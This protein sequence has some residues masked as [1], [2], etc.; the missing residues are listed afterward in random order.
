MT[1]INTIS[2]NSHNHSNS[3]LVFE[4]QLALIPKDSIV[5]NRKISSEEKIELL[6]KTNKSNLNKNNSTNQNKTSIPSPTTHQI[7]NKI[8]KQREI[9]LPKIPKIPI[10][11]SINPKNLPKQILHIQ[12]NNSPS[13]TPS[14][15]KDQNSEFSG[16]QF[17][18]TSIFF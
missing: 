1:Q 5:G 18:N 8:D 6:D 12:P 3:S 9:D 14:V 13:P 15:T 10:P 17:S 7:I 4:R 11:A 16:D 2:Q